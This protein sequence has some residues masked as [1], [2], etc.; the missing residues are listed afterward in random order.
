[1]SQ[2]VWLSD[3]V[4]VCSGRRLACITYM[5]TYSLSCLTKH[6]GEY[7]ILML[8]RLLGGIS[9]SLLFSA[10]ESWLVAEHFARGFNE[11]LL[12]DTFSKA[13]FLGAGLMA[14]LSGLAGNVLVE[15]LKLGPVRIYRAGMLDVARA[16]CFLQG[17]IFLFLIFAPST[18]CA[19]LCWSCG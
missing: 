7:W 5:I 16:S 13:V 14:I 9:T 18:A 2:R 1:M 17:S 10:F 19:T 15:D 4:F 8:G 6:Y 11:A 12:G 3:G